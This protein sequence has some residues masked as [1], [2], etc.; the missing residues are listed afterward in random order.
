MT[1]ILDD[2]LVPAFPDCSESRVAREKEKSDHDCTAIFFDWFNFTCE[3]VLIGS[4]ILYESPSIEKKSSL[5]FAAITGLLHRCYRI[6]MSIMELTQ[7]AKFGEVASILDRCV[8][9]RP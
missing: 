9:E 5:H 8:I 3:L 6:M 1:S 7:H 4:S 2:L